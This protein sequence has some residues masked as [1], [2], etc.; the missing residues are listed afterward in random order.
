[1]WPGRAIGGDLFHN[2]G[3]QLPAA[4]GRVY[5]SA[6]LDATCRSRGPRRLVYSN[7]G[8]IYVTLDHYSS[9]VAVP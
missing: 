1:V 5:R 4:S 7:D 8:Q 2:F 6:D 9:F 3:G